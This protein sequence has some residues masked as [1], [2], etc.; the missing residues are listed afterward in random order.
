MIA[1]EPTSLEMNENM[2]AF[3]VENADGNSPV[4][5]VCDHAGV[6]LP[7]DFDCLG[8][9]DSILSQH[10]AWDIGALEVTRLLGT[11]F[12]SA[13]VSSVYSRLL[14]D[15]NRFPDHP[16]WIPETSDGIEITANKKLTDGERKR[17]ADN[18]FWPYQNAVAAAVEKI[19]TRGQV[20]VVVSVHSFTPS[21]NDGVQRPWHCGILWN[22]DDRLAS[23]MMTAL[24]KNTAICVGDNQPYHANKPAGYTVKTHAE[25][26]GH[27]HALIEIRQDLIDSEPGIAEWA[28]ILGDAL[29]TVFDDCRYFQC[30]TPVG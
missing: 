10:V 24:R 14:V 1:E 19:V 18:Y 21:L 16:S 22:E 7:D 12:D 25:D 13:T 27:P 26:A 15:L 29:Q 6:A 9:D 8:L 3:F 20:P 28:S 23:P 30:T 5:F 11:R 4:L 2:M 17:R